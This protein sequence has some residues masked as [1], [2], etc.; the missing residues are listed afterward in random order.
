MK[1]WMPLVAA[2][3]AL[4]P[5][6]HAQEKLVV[7]GYSADQTRHAVEEIVQP[8]SGRQ[9]AR[10]DQTVCSQFIGFPAGVEENFQSHLAERFAKY[11]V[12][13]RANCR[14]PRLFILATVRED[15]LISHI[16]D[17]DPY[18]MQGLDTS[19]VF[20]DNIRLPSPRVK[21]ALQE[22]YPVRWFA[23]VGIEDAYHM[24]MHVG[25]TLMGP[26]YVHEPLVTSFLGSQTVE[27]IKYMAVTVDLSK[28]DGVSWPSLYE[29]VSMIALTNPALKDYDTTESI[30]GSFV[31]KKQPQ[32]GSFFMTNLDDAIVHQVYSLDP[33]EDGRSETQKITWDVTA[34]LHH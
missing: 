31:Q 26:A 27:T 3:L 5:S 15:D 13:L 17:R 32:Q 19:P 10:W 24:P 33:A 21:K 34:S 7:Q 16:L 25:P 30:L 12:H 20:N 23:D 29:Y 4:A 8:A 6:L 22:S 28:M 1:V 11:G 18:L 9:I 14:I 2:L